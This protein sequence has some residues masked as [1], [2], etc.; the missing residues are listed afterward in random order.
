MKLL[1]AQVVKDILGDSIDVRQKLKLIIDVMDM[2]VCLQ[3]KNSEVSISGVLG[4]ERC[5]DLRLSLYMYSVH[6]C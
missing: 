1:C 4:W 2:Y 5:P 3:G 6:N